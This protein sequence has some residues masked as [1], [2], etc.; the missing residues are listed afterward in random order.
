MK[1]YLCCMKGSYQEYSNGI[2]L[3]NL[4][5]DITEKE[6][7][8]EYECLYP[9][10]NI[11]KDGIIEVDCKVWAFGADSALDIMKNWANRYYPKGE[12]ID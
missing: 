5:E 6:K 7:T 8:K 12:T 3:F 10:K 2:I 1:C 9:T 11:A 4:I